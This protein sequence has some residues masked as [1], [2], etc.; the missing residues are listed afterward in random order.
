MVQYGR[1][2]LEV[3]RKTRRG[4]KNITKELTQ[5]DEFPL[6]G[7]EKLLQ[8]RFNDWHSRVLSIKAITNVT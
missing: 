3:T 5:I 6:I 4:L 2:R 7:Y 1:T 8:I